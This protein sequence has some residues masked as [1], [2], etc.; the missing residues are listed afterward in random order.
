M[1]GLAWQARRG[2]LLPWVIYL[3]AARVQQSTVSSVTDPL[4]QSLHLFLL[5]SLHGKIHPCP[6]SFS[7]QGGGGE[8]RESMGRGCF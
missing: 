5:Q 1:N 6:F 2:S 4:R 3:P 7:E 8:E